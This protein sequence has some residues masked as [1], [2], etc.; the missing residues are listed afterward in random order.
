MEITT[1]SGNK[2]E[3]D[4]F[5]KDHEFICVGLYPRNNTLEFNGEEIE[6]FDFKIPYH[7]NKE[8]IHIDWS[9]GAPTYVPYGSTEVLYDDGCELNDV[10]C[11]DAV[12]LDESEISIYTSGNCDSDYD[13]VSYKELEELLTEDADEI[14]ETV[15]KIA[16]KEAISY[17]NDYYLDSADT[18]DLISEREDDYDHYYY[19]D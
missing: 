11:S 5:D 2:Y 12:E 6:G 7:V 13:E 1:K 10:D 19:E 4:C 16:E 18:W 3:L 9:K 14:Y 8:D 17:N 15:I